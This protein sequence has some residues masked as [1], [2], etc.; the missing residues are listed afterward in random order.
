MKKIRTRIG[1]HNWQQK[2]PNFCTDVKAEKFRKKRKRL[3]EIETKKA[4]KFAAREC[5]RSWLRSCVVG[6][7]PSISF[8]EHAEQANPAAHPMVGVLLICGHGR[9]E[10]E[11]C[12]MTRR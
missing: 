12:G 5:L 2:R 9:P 8:V 7:S 4:A 10:D 3:V 1:T 6:R 11:V